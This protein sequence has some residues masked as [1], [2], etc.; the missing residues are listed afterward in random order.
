MLA[1]NHW[2]M[3]AAQAQL[4]ET[5]KW[6]EANNVASFAENQHP[7]VGFVCVCVCVSDTTGGAVGACPTQLPSHTKQFSLGLALCTY[8][9]IQPPHCIPHA[10][11]SSNDS[12]RCFVE[13]VAGTPAS[14]T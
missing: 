12:R 4:G 5:M 11:R 8:L 10:I 14:P 9:C 1:V 13:P 2:D 6:R 7:K 3:A